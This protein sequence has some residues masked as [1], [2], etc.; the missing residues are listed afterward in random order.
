MLTIKELL[1]LF[2]FG[3]NEE[4]DRCEKFCV[5]ANGLTTDINPSNQLDIAAYGDFIVDYIYV[6]KYGV[7][8]AI[9][10]EFCKAGA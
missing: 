8:I 4:E 2:Q 3:P 7:E 5:S 10:A 9:K 1:P 6:D